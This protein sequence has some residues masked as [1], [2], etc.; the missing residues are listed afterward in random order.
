MATRSSGSSR[1]ALNVSPIS[2]DVLR[3]MALA[4]GRSSVTSRIAPSRRV[5]MTSDMS[6]SLTHQQR[7]RDPGALA[8]GADDQRVDVEFL[9]RI[10][11]GEHEVGDP[12]DRVD[13]RVRDRP[14]AG[15][16]SRRAAETVSG[17]AARPRY[18]RGVAGSSSVALSFNSSTSTPPEPTVITGP[19]SGSRV[20]P[21]ISSATPPSHHALDIEAG[22]KRRS[23]ARPRRAPRLRRFRLSLTAPAS[24]LW[25]TPSAFSATGKPSAIAA[26]TAS[27]TLAGATAWRHGKAGFASSALASASSR[28]S[29][30][31]LV[32]EGRC[33]A[34]GWRRS[35]RVPHPPA[36]PLR[37]DLPTRGR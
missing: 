17:R 30:L 34:P 5:V 3:S 1:N 12:Q 36:R 25:A 24:D 31:P 29:T 33:A 22:A 15:R 20:K 13:R 18:R 14:S 4:F 19:N 10:G 8:F 23:A 35:W 28:V 6:L 11:I 16:E 7:I 21:T 27:S 2:R 32:G 9:D 26:A 37:A